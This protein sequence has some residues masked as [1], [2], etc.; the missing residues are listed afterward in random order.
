M[1]DYVIMELVNTITD[2]PDWQSKVFDEGIVAK[3]RT[4]ILGPS[5][6]TAKPTS[7]PANTTAAKL[8]N[9]NTDTDHV[10]AMDVSSR[11]FDWVIAEVR[12][13]AEVFKQS[14]CIEAPDGVWKSDTILDEKLRTALEKAVRPLEDIPESE[15]DWHPGSSGQVLDLVHPSIYP[16]VYGQSRI[17]ESDTCNVGGSWIGKASI[18]QLPKGSDKLQGEWSKNYQWLPTE[19][20]ALLGTE[21]VIVKSYI[22]NLHPSNSDLYSIISQ[23]VTK[24]IPL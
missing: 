5:S 3:W 21:D 18:L 17:L 7:V 11:I 10:A 2:K 8:T 13:K 6:P 19:F 16:L 15:K 1:R 24:A 22:N 9:T 14:N 12:Y 20:E 4:E 23:I